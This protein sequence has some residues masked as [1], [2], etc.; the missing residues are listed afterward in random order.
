MK[1]SA[2]E[3]A[4]LSYT[5]LQDFIEYYSATLEQLARYIG[6]VAQNLAIAI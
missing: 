6:P 2:K 5:D 3:R 4:D 1:A